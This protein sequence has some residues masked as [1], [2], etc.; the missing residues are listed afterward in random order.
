VRWTAELV[1]R[2]AGG[3]QAVSEQAAAMASVNDTLR[4][5][6]SLLFGAQRQARRLLG[7]TGHPC[8]VPH[9]GWTTRDKAVVLGRVIEQDAPFL[10]GLARRPRLV[11]AAYDRFATMPIAGVPLRIR[12]EGQLIETT[13]GPAGFVDVTFPL[14]PDGLPRGITRAQLEVVGD[15][16]LGVQ[17]EVHAL[18]PDTRMAVISDIDDTVLETEVTNPFKRAAQLMYSTRRMRLPFD[19]IAAL[20]QA[21]A[22]SGHAI[23]YVSNAPWN[24]YAP[25]VTLLDHHAIPRGPVL[26]RDMGLVERRA[27][28]QEGVHKQVALSR[29]VEDFSD[30]RFVLLGDSTRSDAVRYVEVA[31]RYPRRVEVIYIRKVPGLLSRNADLAPL[32][33]RAERV[34]VELFVATDTVAIAAHAA[35]RG[36][37]V[38]RG[39]D[40]VSEGKRADEQGTTA[41]ASPR[42]APPAGDTEATAGR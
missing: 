9:R 4:A 2:G 40:H 22:G 23:F 30:L 5:L 19:G 3:G 16:A 33:A 39:V 13:S 7:R 18:R 17:A 12:W 15:G 26:L 42:D 37:L 20:Y 38:P 31:E 1:A 32:V 8:I 6:D 11:Q 21:F 29:L 41:E 34:G 25:L 27:A 28:N 35:A 10:G 36:L 24:L 14:P